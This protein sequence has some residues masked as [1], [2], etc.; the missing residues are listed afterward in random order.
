MK[1]KKRTQRRRRIFV[2]SFLLTNIFIVAFATVALGVFIYDS[3]LIFPNVSVNGVNLSG[4]TINQAVDRLVGLGFENNTVSATVVFPD[5]SDFSISGSDAGF[6]LCAE[7]VANAAFRHGRDGSFFGHIHMYVTS[8]WVPTDINDTSALDENFVRGEVAA[9]TDL[10]NSGLVESPSYIFN[11]CSI[12]V[13]PGASSAPAN[14][15]AVFRLVS[16]ALHDAL[17]ENG[18]VTVHY[19]PAAGDSLSFD[20]GSLYHSVRTDPVPAFFDAETFAVTDGIPGVSFD[21]DAAM[22][23]LENAMPGER[24]VIPLIF[25]DPEVTAESLH[26]KLFRDELAYRTT[27]VAGTAARL[28][29]VVVA[30]S[31]IDGMVL[32]PGDVFSFNE[33]VGR[34][35]EARGFRPAGG[36]RDGQLVDMVGGGICQV[37]SSLYDNVLHAY[38]EVVRRRA[39]TLPIT[40]LPL[41][42]DAAIYYGVLDFRFRN[43]TNYPIRIEIEFDEREMTTRIVGTR[44]DDYTIQIESRSTAVPFETVYLEYANHPYN[45]PTVH[46]AGRNGFIA[47]TYRLI[48]DAEGNRVSRTRI[49]RDV[50]RAQNRIMHIQPADPP[51]QET[52]PPAYAPPEPSEQP[53]ANEFVPD[54]ENLPDIFSNDQEV[55][56]W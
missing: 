24:I 42:H 12:T 39:H 44:T 32:N 45:E 6:S 54:I 34:S 48:Y 21:A 27:D 41:G 50:Y 11:G 51:P 36:F 52:S 37:A 3:D 10:F 46:F 28:N 20:L 49:A 30:A 8:L 15:D 38:L 43:N 25:T 4:M 18:E 47:Y 53:P 29:N 7:E 9:H 17:E 5:G 55:L 16:Q 31:Y 13:I 19:S 22:N 56:F 1:K 40:Y 33:T 14:E 35:S 26:E 2:V 23:Q